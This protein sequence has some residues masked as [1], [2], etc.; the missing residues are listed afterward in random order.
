MILEGQQG[1]DSGNKNAAEHTNKAMKN[2]LYTLLVL[3]FISVIY[4]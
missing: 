2:Y 4:M 3:L 1:T